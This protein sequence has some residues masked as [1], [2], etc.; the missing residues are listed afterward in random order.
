MSSGAELPRPLQVTLRVEAGHK[1]IHGARTALAGQRAVG[2]A[3]HVDPTAVAGQSGCGI[4]RTGAELPRPLQVALRV[5]AGHER[6]VG[7]R[8]ALAGQRAVGDA[9]DVDPTA[10]RSQGGGVGARTGAELPRPLQVTFRVEAGHKRIPVARAALAGQRAAGTARHVDP[11]AVRRQ[12]VGVIRRAGAELPGPSQVEY[13]YSGSMIK[14][15]VREGRWGEADELTLQNPRL[16]RTRIQHR[17]NVQHFH[18]E[19]VGGRTS[20]VVVHRDSHRV[21]A[22]VGVRVA[23]AYHARP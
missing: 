1:R 9:R 22:V 23:A 17:I 3:R 15:W 19:R 14:S 16:V 20:V 11:A 2:N 12:G 5:E 4:V 21:R 8:T 10:V 7:A 6:I 18:L 13:T